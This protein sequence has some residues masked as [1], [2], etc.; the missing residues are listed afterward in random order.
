MWSKHSCRPGGSRFEDGAF[1]VLFFPIRNFR[2][3]AGSA[4]V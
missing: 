4:N 3:E 1:E 2:F